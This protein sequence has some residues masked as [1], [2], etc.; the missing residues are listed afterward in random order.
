MKLT[1]HDD[2][3]WT[4]SGMTDDEVHLLASGLGNQVALEARLSE[5]KGA[6]PGFGPDD[7]AYFARRWRR[8]D[9][10]RAWLD[11]ATRWGTGLRR[12]SSSTY[13]A[14]EATEAV[15]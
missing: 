9:H 12:R 1:H 4:L 15:A 8:T 13:V 5:G 11:H 6:W 14:P 7:A 10:V 3:T 2:H